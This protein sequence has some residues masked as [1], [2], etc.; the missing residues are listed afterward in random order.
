MHRP[1]VRRK[2]ENVRI[3]T[4]LYQREFEIISIEFK[5]RNDIQPQRAQRVDYNR[6][7]RERAQETANQQYNNSNISP[8]LLEYA[9]PFHYQSENNQGKRYQF[10]NLLL[11]DQKY[12]QLKKT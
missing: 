6:L 11:F 2:F 3:K 9:Y 1:P 12:I 5:D 4:Y 8:E 7:K 10:T